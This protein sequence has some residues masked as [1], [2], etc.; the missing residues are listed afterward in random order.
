MLLIIFLKFLF[1]LY[2]IFWRTFPDQIL[3]LNIIFVKY[4]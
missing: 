1:L 2:Y 4:F 3:L